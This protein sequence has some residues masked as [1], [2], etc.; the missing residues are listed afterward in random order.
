MSRPWMP[1]YVADYLA[2]TAHLTTV[3]HGAYLLLIMHYWQKG[4]LPDDDKRL[5]GIARLSVKQWADI[6]PTIEEFF[7]PAWT[8]GRIDAELQSASAA[9]E[10]RAKAGRKGGNA[11]AM[12]QQC[13]GNDVA[14]LKQ[15]QPQPHRHEEA[16]AS[17]GSEPNGS[18]AGAPID[19]E[20]MAFS[21]GK[22]VLGNSAGGVIARL[23]RDHCKTWPATVAAIEE[24]A[25]KHSP[26]EWVQGILRK[27]DPDE[28]IYRNV[29]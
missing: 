24:A 11:K 26:M 10:R 28:E 16:N 9:Y 7:G 15:S 23:K 4:S 13:S 2:D 12:L 17:S 5:S 21:R 27:A 25:G 8:H 22:A 18:G 20:K 6:R 14:G 3:E 29:L 19:F 1:L